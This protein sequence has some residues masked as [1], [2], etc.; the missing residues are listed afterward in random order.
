MCH[1]R[2]G[3]LPRSKLRHADD[4]NSATKHSISITNVT[5]K[6]VFMCRNQV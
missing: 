1:N 2:Y 3:I 6:D 4:E 5:H